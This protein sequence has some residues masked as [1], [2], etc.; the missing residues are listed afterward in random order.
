M[1]GVAREVIYAPMRAGSC[2][3]SG[4]AAITSQSRLHQTLGPRDAETQQDRAITPLRGTRSRAGPVKRAVD[5]DLGVSDA[6]VEVVSWLPVPLVADGCCRVGGFRLERPEPGEE[7]PGEDERAGCRRAAHY[8]EGLQDRYASYPLVS[9]NAVS[10]DQRC[11]AFV[12]VAPR[13][14]R[15]ISSARASRRY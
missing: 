11:A 14:L 3:P 10:P 4:V 1:G 7:P 15:A 5:L 6:G 9:A 12:S 2:P 13:P 8:Y